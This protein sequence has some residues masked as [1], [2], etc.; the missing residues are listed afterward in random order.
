MRRL[1][2]LGLLVTLALPAQGQN[3][4][5]SLEFKDILYGN[6]VPLSLKLKDLNGDWRR[7]GIAAPGGSGNIMGSLMKGIFGAMLGGGG[8]GGTETSLTTYYTK[9]QT[10]NIGG[11]TFIVAYRAKLKQ[12]DFAALIA[13]SQQKDKEGKDKEPDLEKL[14]PEKL[15]PDSTL[16]LSL[17]TLKSTGSLHDIRPFDMKQEIEE[18]GK[19]DGGLG[20][21]MALGAAADKDKKAGTPGPIVNTVGPTVPSL[22]ELAP[23]VKGAIGKD[24]PLNRAP[25]TITVE[26]G[27]DKALHLKGHVRSSALKVH[28]EEVAQKVLD[29]EAPFTDLVNDLTVSGGAKTTGKSTGKPGVHRNGK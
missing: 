12:P 24:S 6:T 23:K 1:A 3:N 11:E 14:K 2:V 29:S 10:V 21:L 20:E 19:E 4:T 28:A 9:G 18:S 26:V 7:V 16:T 13:E 25:N 8:G 22:Q 27:A 5:Q 15:N 17:L